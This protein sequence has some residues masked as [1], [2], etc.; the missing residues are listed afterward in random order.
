MEEK[1]CRKCN[2]LKPIEEF[3]RNAKYR[4]HQCKNCVSEYHKQRHTLNPSR[5]RNAQLKYWYGIDLQEYDMLAAKQLNRCKI[6]N[7]ITKLNVDHD[8]TTNSIRGLLCCNCNRGLGMF[9]DNIQLLSSA[10]EYL[11][12]SK[13]HS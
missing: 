4:K 7:E 13:N 1:H 5:K 12:Q 9:K 6:C 10:I 2:L 11:V 3:N 8:H